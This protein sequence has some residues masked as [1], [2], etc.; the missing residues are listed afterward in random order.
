MANQKPFSSER[1]DQKPCSVFILLDYHNEIGSAQHVHSLYH[2]H[3]QFNTRITLIPF[4]T[5]LSMETLISEP[6]CE[7]LPLGATP[8]RI[9]SCSDT[10]PSKGIDRST[11]A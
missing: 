1:D 3:V 4:Q 11:V 2:G 8:L 10:K 5:F 6:S 9:S 7:L